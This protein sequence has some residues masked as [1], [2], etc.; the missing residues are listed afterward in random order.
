MVFVPVTVN[1]ITARHHSAGIVSLYR[2][3]QWIGNAE[4]QGCVWIQPFKPIEGITEALLADLSVA[5]ASSPQAEWTIRSPD[6]SS[7]RG[8]PDRKSAFEEYDRLAAH[9]AEH[10]GDYTL[11]FNG[12]RVE[13]I[14]RRVD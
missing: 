7:D 10:G 5:V 1:G 4:H 12:V 11:L 3:E 9:A 6:W 14:S 8:F 13:S 2:S